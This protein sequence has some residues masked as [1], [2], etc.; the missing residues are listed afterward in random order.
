MSPA[1]VVYDPEWMIDARGNGSFRVECQC[2][3]EDS[4]FDTASL[5]R[6]A[7]FNHSTTGAGTPPPADGAPAPDG[8]KRK[9]FW[10]R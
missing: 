8:G 2:G 3:W 4:G 10:R 9:R 7:G 5:A 1:H 6:S